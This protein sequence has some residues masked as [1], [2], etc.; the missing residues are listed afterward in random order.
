MSYFHKK[1]ISV[2][3]SAICRYYICGLQSL[4]RTITSIKHKIG[5]IVIYD[6]PRFKFKSKAQHFI[7]LNYETSD[8]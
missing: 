1:E 4:Q 5:N 2:I 7:D 3:L 8:S 6:F